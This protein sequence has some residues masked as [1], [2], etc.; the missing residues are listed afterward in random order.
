[1]GRLIAVTGCIALLAVLAT[2][3][4]SVRG[5]TTICVGSE[6]GCVRTIQE[7][8]AR[9]HAG[10]TLRIGRGTFAGGITI[11]KSLSLVGA[12]P[13]AT[14]VKGGGPVITITPGSRRVALARLTITGGMTTHDPLRR[15]GADIPTCGPGYLRATALGGG[16]EIAAATLDGPGKGAAVTITDSVVTGN[17][18]EPRVIVPSVIAKCPSGPCPF[19]QA[20]GGGIDNWGSLTLIRTRVTNNAAAGKLTA[21]TDGGGILGEDGSSLTLEASVVS[22]N[23]AAASAPNGRLAAGGGV[24]LFRRGTLDVRSSAINGNTASLTTDFPATVSDLNANSGGIFVANAGSAT[25]DHATF[26]GNRVIVSAPA[27]RAAGFD[28][29]LLVTASPLKLSNSLIRGNSVTVDV[30]TSVEGGSGG[31]LEAGTYAAIDHVRV[32]GNRVTV[33][34]ASGRALATGVVNMF[35]NGPR[36]GVLADSVI[37]GNTVRASSK[38]GMA[39]IQGVGLANNGPLELRHVRITGNTGTATG[40]AG[41]A[42]GGG[43]FNGLVFNVPKP[44]LELVDVTLTGNRLAGSPGLAVQ[45]AGLYTACFSVSRQSTSIAR[46]TPDDCFGCG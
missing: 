7:G 21:Q 14:I 5:T 38:T 33:T 12:G 27:A 37:S 9:A 29:A 36:G 22:G 3:L 30:G 1:M 10:D 26:T 13:G 6:A 23:V 34:S 17:R 15:C 18:A 25:I 28:S 8:L 43:I 45:G 2:A 44:K 35:V 39:Q 11:T 40:A 20:G 41:W 16:I 31:G 42:H 46:N 24:Y 4:A 19:A 32:I